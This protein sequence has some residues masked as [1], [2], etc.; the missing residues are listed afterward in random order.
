MTNRTIM[1]SM[2]DRTLELLLMA[3][4]SALAAGYSHMVD[5]SR[6]CINWLLDLQRTAEDVGIDDPA[7]TALHR[8]ARQR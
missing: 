3:N 8:V 7:A 2:L 4:C 1:P 5:E 6:A